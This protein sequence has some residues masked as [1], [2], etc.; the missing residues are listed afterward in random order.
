VSEPIRPRLLLVDDDRDFG[1]DLAAVLGA[2]YEVHLATDPEAALADA[3]RRDPD[4]VLLDL[5]FGEGR[6]LLGLEL[7]ER[8]AAGEDPPAVIMLTG[9]REHEHT[10]AAVKAGAF[11]Y[12]VKPPRPEEM[13]L[14][15]R[16]AVDDVRRRRQLQ[17]ERGLTGAGLDVVAVDPRT[18]RV[19]AEVE[20]VAGSD[21]SVL[22]T[23]ESGTGK[24]VV[25]RRLHALSRR[26]EGPFHEFNCGAAPSSEL[27]RSELFGHERGAFTDAS[28]RR[29]GRFE[30]AEGGTLF[31]DEVAE[32]PLTVQPYL[33]RALEQR[34]FE[35]LGG[36]EVQRADVRLVA[37]THRSLETMIAAGS[38]RED[39][40]YRLNVFPIHMPA[41]R[42]RPADILPLARLFLSRFAGR[43]A[44]DITG[45]T[46]HAER[47]L[48][49][50]AWPGNVREL[51]NVI[52]RAVIRARRP[53]LGIDALQLGSTDWTRP[54][55]PY[56]EWRTE[57]ADRSR[58]SYV[59]I[60]LER[61]GGNVTQAAELSGVQRSAFQ[62]M[63]RACGIRSEEF[64]NDDPPS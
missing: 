28:Q 20:Q 27:V 29:R 3:D 39:L 46:P 26:R 18:R 63:M 33:L 51:S 58:C 31:L 11:D 52:E 35:R 6:R 47:V 55:P 30:L 13:F 9:N 56:P 2:T 64:R 54:L 4:V 12:L 43:A 53:L 49:E 42:E 40:Y 48:Q 62:A 1:A 36:E 19:F 10:V 37:A 25:A 5:D 41:L 61:T 15:L 24:E 21:T 17:A 8:I 16:R 23:G 34:T 22:I 44:R 50:Y 60:Q 59:R 32:L 14:R 45:F 38:F 57:Q 7:L